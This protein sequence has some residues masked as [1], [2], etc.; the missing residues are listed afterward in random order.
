[1]HFRITFLLELY[2]A[3]VMKNLQQQTMYQQQPP[4]WNGLILYLAIVT[5]MRFA[6]E[7]NN[8]KLLIHALMCLCA[9]A[10]GLMHSRS[11]VLGELGLPPTLQWSER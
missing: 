3:V 2:N 1:M 11:A 8:R 6:V 9:V 5:S 4:M 7:Q 10:I